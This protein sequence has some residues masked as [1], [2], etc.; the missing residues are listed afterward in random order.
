MSGNSRHRVLLIHQYYEPLRGA[1]SVVFGVERALRELGHEPIIFASR[2]SD[3]IVTPRSEYFPPGFK[4]T[5]LTRTSPWAR[6]RQAI[7]GVYSFPARSHLGRLIRATGADTAIVFRPEYQLSY[8]VMSELRRRGVPNA[9]WLVDYRFW[10]SSGFL[11]NPALGEVCFRCVGGAHWNAIRYRCSE[12]SLTR[13]AYDAAVRF[14]SHSLLALHRHADVFVVPTEATRHLVVAR[15]G[16]PEDRVTVIGH[17]L[18]MIHH[19][20][21]IN[22]A[23]H[24][25]VVFYGRLSPEKGVSTLLEAIE[26]TPRLKLEVYALDPLGLRET[27]ADEIARRGLADRVTFSTTLRFG[28]ELMTRISGALAVV[29]PSVW[30]DTSDYVLLESMALGK[31][32]VVSDSGGNAEIVARARGGMIYPA[33]DAAALSDLLGSLRDRELKA[34]GERA[35]RFIKDEYAPERFRAHVAAVV[36]RLGTFRH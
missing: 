19:T 28:H 36:D 30:P 8:S 5:E 4:R 12:G 24:D 21:G 32:V 10:C 22:A 17:P 11:Y 27:V 16:L 26:R 34:M 15:L 25:Y 35:A 3:G 18:E 14:V 31:A 6:I 33:G 29:L 7:N 2:T 13:S 1:F 20:R 9:L 23:D